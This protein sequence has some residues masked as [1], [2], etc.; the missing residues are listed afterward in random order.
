MPL[1]KSKPLIPKKSAA[2]LAGRDQMKTNPAALAGALSNAAAKQMNILL[3][4]NQS[5]VRKFGRFARVLRSDRPLTDD[6]IR[7]VAPSIFA[8]QAHGSRSSRYAYIPTSEVLASLRREGFLPFMVTQGGTRDE[9]KTGFTKHMIR[10]RHE[11]ALT[12]G[13]G[14]TF[15][16]VVLVNSHDGTSS[17]Q[18]MDGM[19]RLVCS[20]GMVVGAGSGFD[21]VRVKHSGD[22]TSQVI[23]GCI[24]ILNRLPE[25]SEQVRD[26]SGLSLTAGEQGAFARA[27]L[28]LKYEDDE[29]P[30]TSDKL[31][32]V[33]RRDDEKPTL[34][35]T[36]NTVQENV[37]GGGIGYILRDEQGRRKQA[38]RTGEVRGIDQ[39]VKL[40][41]GLWVLAEEMRK[42][43]ASMN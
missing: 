20:N 10:L 15:N 1:S 25:V 30:I 35:N 17:Y 24:E 28:A 7:Q 40:N 27:A 38:R 36:L 14:E 9:E 8:E 41:K 18:L 43:K 21:E 34:W 11:S 12:V 39:N 4:Q 33:R 3:R 32:T 5:N 31:L 16:E 19:F 26:W 2:S 42:L 22:V 13:V 6:Q 29:A 23:D 37:I